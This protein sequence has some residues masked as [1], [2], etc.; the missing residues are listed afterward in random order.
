MTQGM[1]ERADEPE[2]T[3][4]LVVDD[5]RTFTDLLALALAEQPDLRCVGTAHTVEEGLA[6]ADKL[7]PDVVVMDV[8]LGDGD[9]LAATAALMSRHPQM[10]VV[11]LTAHATQDLLERAGA[12]GACC[13][14]PKDGA[15]SDMLNALR[16]S[17]RDG[18]VVHP[19]LLK[20][21]M[22][23]R[24]EPR[25]YLPPLTAREA[26]V[27]RML[28]EGLDARAISRRLDIS[29]NTCRGYVRG[30]LGKL[31]AHSQLEAVAIAKR[32]GLVDGVERS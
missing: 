9:G 1:S 26:D 30:V 2:Q 18:L 11:V 27:L 19:L 28:A 29:L 10:R 31:D 15:L 5:H 24:R 4:V 3:S 32:H 16:T 6:L 14:L 20:T 22:G 17:R 7:L 23:A 25:P 13:L 8:R 12:A 21:L